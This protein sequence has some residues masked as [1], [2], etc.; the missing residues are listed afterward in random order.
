M[1]RLVLLSL[2]VVAACDPQSEPEVYLGQLTAA[3]PSLTAAVHNPFEAPASIDLSA[4]AGV[5]LSCSEYCPGQE[6]RSGDCLGATHSIEPAELGQIHPVDLPNRS[7]V[8]LLI[9]GEPGVGE[10]TVRTSCA[11]KV[12]R[13][14]VI[15]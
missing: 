11:E 5:G 4:G 12:Y 10:L 8:A 14:R 6:R 9:G 3:P 7:G 1:K 2:L 13:L 15:E